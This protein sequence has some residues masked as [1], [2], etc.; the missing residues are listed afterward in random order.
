MKRII[1]LLNLIVALNTIVLAQKA[2]TKPWNY[3][4]SIDF[5]DSTLYF[6]VNLKAFRIKN[7]I[8]NYFLFNRYITID[9]AYL[10][11][12]TLNFSRSN[13]TLYFKTNDDEL[14]I[15]LRYKIPC[16]VYESLKIIKA[17][18]D[19]V[20]AYPVQFDK[21]QIFFERHNK[22]FPVIY[23]NFSNF[24]V[25]ISVP[26]SYKVLG[27]YSETNTQKSK[28]KIIYSYKFFDEDLRFLIT[29]SDIFQYE[30]L[31]EY[32]N[33]YFK[34]SFLPKKKRLLSLT[35][36]TPKY[37]TETSQMDSIYNVISN[38]SVEAFKWYNNN[39]WEQKFDTLEFVESGIFGVALNM[40]RFIL[41]DRSLMNME[42]IDK[43][44]FSHEIGHFW[45]G[46]NIKYLSKGFYFLAES[47]DEFN[48]LLFFESWAGK[49]EF[50]N[51]IKNKINMEYSDKPFFTV[52]FDQVLNQRNSVLKTE[53]IYNKG[54]VFV[55]EFFKMIGKEK[56][57]K[58]IRDTYFN[59]KHPITLTD[60]EENIKKNGC[61][62]EY[63]KLFE[64][65][66]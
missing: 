41:F 4:I 24:E 50:E 11:N 29:K 33:T 48:N 54:V 18:S 16:S 2:E 21:N 62:D 58:I 35:N 10:N 8:Q 57:L 28:N 42:A 19:S 60:F 55:Y 22:F 36:N 5:K 66:I 23:D 37:A 53:I 56:Y 63:L 38:R 6:D 1:I 43:Y 44:W 12:D 64:L 39:L 17:Y 61:W 14:N 3:N 25:N 59:P 52:T 49:T 40:R 31:I 7:R 65:N 46:Y 15:N 9:E 47:I 26:G 34:F 27:E 30:K 45:V 32:N 20:F 51:A 13:D